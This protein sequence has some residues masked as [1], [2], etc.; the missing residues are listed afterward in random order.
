MGDLPT[1]TILSPFVLSI[2]KSKDAFF[3]MAL[4]FMQ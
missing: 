4:S 3:H 1:L 2:A